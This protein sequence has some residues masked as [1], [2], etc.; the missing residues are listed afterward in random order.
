MHFPFRVFSRDCSEALDCLQFIFFYLTAVSLNTSRAE[1]GPWGG[2]LYFIYRGVELVPFQGWMRMGQG[3]SAQDVPNCQWQLF[4]LLSLLFIYSL[5]SDPT[6]GSKDGS[7]HPQIPN[8]AFSL[9]HMPWLWRKSIN[10]RTQ[11]HGMDL[12]YNLSVLPKAPVE[13]WFKNDQRRPGHQEHPRK[14]FSVPTEGQ[15]P[16]AAR[17]NL[18]HPLQRSWPLIFWVTKLTREPHPWVCRFSLHRHQLLTPAHLQLSLLP[19]GHWSQS[20]WQRRT[21]FHL[22]PLAPIPVTLVSR[23]STLPGI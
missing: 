9:L 17:D 13:V 22:L 6:Q 14:S 20:S 23:C 4:P 5:S 7:G 8:M 10:H 2:H 3:P 19:K 16:R 12:S 15:E 11:T 1:A 21:L 18:V